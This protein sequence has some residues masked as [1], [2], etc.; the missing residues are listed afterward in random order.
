MP[1]DIFISYSRRDLSVVKP[2]KEEL[3]RLGFSCWMDLSDIPAGE[4]NYKRRIIPAIRD[5]RVAFLF[6]LSAQSQASENALK[7]IGFAEK[8]AK[9]RIVLIQFNDD[10]MTDDFFYDYQNAN[11]ID[12]RKPEQ[13]TKL[14]QDLKAWSGVDTTDA[15]EDENPETLF[16]LALRYKTGNGVDRN[17]Q[18]AAALFR[19]AAENGH[20]AAMNDYG[21]CIQNGQGVRKNAEEAVRWYRKAA[22]S[23]YD[24][25]QLNLGYCFHRGEGV[26]EDQKEAVRWY[27]ASAEQ[28]N[29]WA[30]CNLGVCYETGAGVEQDETEARYWYEQAAEQG[31]ATAVKALKRLS[32]RIS[33][34]SVATGRFSEDGIQDEDTLAEN[35]PDDSF[36]G[37][38][39]GCSQGRI[40][41]FFVK[42]V[43]GSGA[44]GTVFC[45][46]ERL[47][48]RVVALKILRSGRHGWPN[49]ERYLRIVEI[50]EKLDP[51]SLRFARPLRLFQAG[52][53][54]FVPD[55]S[56]KA[57]D[58]IVEMAFV[59]GVSSDVWARTLDTG[60]PRWPNA[61][62]DVCGQIAEALDELHRAGIFHRDVSPGNV[63]VDREDGETRARLCDF[64][65]S[66][67]GVPEKNIHAAD[68]RRTERV[69]GTPGYIAPEILAGFPVQS[70]SSDQY[71]LACV[72]YRL[73][74]GRI[75]FAYAGDAFTSESLPTRTFG[76][77]ADQNPVWKILSEK[78]PAVPCLNERQ[79][80]ALA[81]ALSL[82]FL[83]RYSSC[84]EMVDAIRTG[85]VSKLGNWVRKRFKF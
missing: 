41:R 48:G 23:G 42:E 11:I 22:E 68:G 39:G 65:F 72:L 1:H 77:V 63:L 10:A 16:Q 28:G 51:D 62:F 27:R 67:S 53:N 80:A 79:N 15:D 4:A 45:A 85:S 56:V 49:V 61:V 9:K 21:V 35:R 70:G 19:R 34:I 75:P 81:K 64:D 37:V 7:E 14:L 82:S 66:T 20:V 83:S 58:W 18:Q 13:K 12:W 60:K 71:S 40:D 30:Q 44:F 74:S 29:V 3:E 36:G 26:A 33:V 69:V 38:S 55:G 76:P 46:E 50:L 73:L 5:S 31:D 24:H 78:P 52:D 59:S 32:G 6:F 84:A 17:L 8:Q 54:D 57:G 25:A 2:I 47:T 43:L